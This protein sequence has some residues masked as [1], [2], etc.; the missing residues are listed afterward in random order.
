VMS[1]RKLNRAASRVCWWIFLGLVVAGLFVTLPFSQWWVYVPALAA[2]ACTVVGGRLT[3][4][5]IR[6]VRREPVE[7]AAPVSGRRSRAVA[8]TRQGCRSRGD[9]GC[10]AR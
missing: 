5:G 9:G 10:A 2:T 1:I 4:R 3:A 6:A 8:A 7:V